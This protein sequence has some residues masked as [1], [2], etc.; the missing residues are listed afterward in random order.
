MENNQEMKPPLSLDEFV[1]TA[2]ELSAMPDA[3]WGVLTRPFTAA[4]APPREVVDRTSPPRQPDLLAFQ[5]NKEVGGSVE[6]AH[7]LGT[8]NIFIEAVLQRRPSTRVRFSEKLEMRTVD[9]VRLF[10][11]ESESVLLTIVRRDD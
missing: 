10:F 3:N 2:N 5:V 1:A 4:T 9:S 7:Y 11:P 6:V 8:T